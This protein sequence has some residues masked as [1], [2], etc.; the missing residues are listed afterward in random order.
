MTVR[1][2]L[3]AAGGAGASGVGGG[4]GREGGRGTGGGAR[5]FDEARTCTPP[6][7]ERTI[8]TSAECFID[9]GFR[10]SVGSVPDYCKTHQVWEGTDEVLLQWTTPYTK[11][12][13]SHDHR[14]FRRRRNLS[15]QPLHLTHRASKLLLS[16]SD[17]TR[18]NAR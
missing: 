4:G 16:C 13:A 14:S 8:R 18:E 2:V 3:E 15:G 1:G 9:R 11:N 6:E 7:E 12:S 5:A 17:R 10:R